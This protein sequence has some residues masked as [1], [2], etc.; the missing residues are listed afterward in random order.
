MMS[1]LTSTDEG[2][3]F[4]SW[5][6]ADTARGDV[7]GRLV[8]ALGAAGVPVW[9]DDGQIGA[10]DPIP[11]AVR[12]GL[13]RSK[14]LLAWYSEAYPT[15]RACREE[16]TLALLAAENAGLGDRRVLVIN[17][18][19]TLEHVVEA[20]L[21][22]RR[23][24]IAE[25]LAEPAALAA[26]IAGRV[27]ELDGPFGSL[28]VSG[29]PH[30]LFGGDGWKGGSH[31]FV[32]RLTELWRVHD[33]LHRT[34][35]LAGAGQAGRSVALVSGFGGVGKSLL[36]AEYA[37]LFASRYPGGVVWLS[38]AGHDPTGAALTAEQSTAAADTAIAELARSLNVDPSSPIDLS[39]LDKS[40]LRGWAKSELD[41][42]G[43]AVLWIVDDIPTRLDAAGLDAWRCPGPLV[44]ELITTRDRG[45]SRFQA[46]NLDVLHPADALSLLTQGRPLPSAEREQAEALAEELGYHP[47]A[48][49]VAGLYIA[50]STTFAG[51]RRLLAGNIGRFDELADQLADQL[52]GGHARQITA[53]LATSLERLGPQAWQLLW[54]AGVLAA[55]PIPRWF[56]VLVFAL[57]TT[58]DDNAAELALNQALQD[59]HCDGLWSYDPASTAVTVHVLVSA[60]ATALD[61]QPPER[62]LVR[63]VATATLA[64]MFE[65]Y[66]S[67][68]GQPARLNEVAVHARHLATHQ[69]AD[70]KLLTAVAFYEYRV[71]RAA[72]AAELWER[73]LSYREQI[74]G[75]EHPDTLI[76][77]SN[78]ASAYKDAGRLDE[79][80]ALFEQTLADSERLLGPDRTETLTSRGNLATAYHAAGRRDEA[81]PLFEQTGTD[82]ERLLG[83]D[84]PYTLTSRNNLASAYQEAGR[85]DRALPLFEQT[86]SDQEW[87]LGPDHPDTL[88]SRSNLASAYKDAGRRDEA[89]PLFEQ[90]LSDRLRILGRDHPDT[91]ASRNNLA[92]AYQDAGRL[93]EALPL[94]E[95]TLTDSERLLSPDHPHTL[96]SRSN[97]ASAYKDA[98][99][100]DEALPLFEQ[101]LSDRLR[102]LGRDHPDT[103]SSR[104]H[105]ALAYHE[106]GRLDEALALFEQTLTDRERFLGTDHPDTLASRLNLA[107]AYHRAGRLDEALPLFEQ[108]RTDSERLLGPDHPH[109]LTS[110]GDLAHAYQDAGRRDQ[111]LALFEQTVTDS[112]R[113]LGTDHPD[114]LASRLNLAVGYHKA[115][116]L[117]EALPLFEQTLTD[118]ERILGPDHP[119]TRTSRHVLGLVHQDARLATAAVSPPTRPRVGRRRWSGWLRRQLKRD[120]KR[121]EKAAN[122]GDIDAMYRF[123]V[124][125]L[126]K[127]DPPD[128]AGARRWFQKA[129][130]AGDRDAAQSLGYLL[131]NRLEPPDLVGARRWFQKAA[132]AGDRDAMVDLG[133][134][135]ADQLDPPDLYGARI[136]Y[137]KAADAGEIVAMYKLAIL[138]S[139]LDPPDLAAADRWIEKAT[140][141]RSRY[142]GG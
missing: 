71:G 17:P 41:R 49:D 36:A 44:H 65:R 108:T 136:W 32:G 37:H 30:W 4:L 124:L 47:L 125:L 11:D 107:N 85:L 102:I 20:R 70:P 40:M 8:D 127:K 22:D 79:A 69:D 72:A 39:S 68:I 80:L 53:T 114:T 98:G 50:G 77:R 15:R 26:R 48:C 132:E 2:G 138:L 142:E 13:G 56:L 86:L 46:V 33:L 95:Q 28:P 16:L 88:T 45:H 122:A 3:V 10:F 5:T 14:V 76:S 12:D 140:A 82:S 101:T 27:A 19:P 25:D 129:A 105:L 63:Q 121:D 134:L 66:R 61:P 87:I 78:L 92:D 111:A 141:A 104:H 21:L 137:E 81:L 73:V 117:D 6:R 135:L 131:A 96:T 24:A 94:F 74:L 67:D 31:R 112:E 58:G 133:D 52:P 29:Q 75:P 115:G 62:E 139:E 34:T 18:E 7:L 93:D 97:L 9:I 91:L 1:E 84:H 64:T 116:R 60:A 130:E 55:A 113:F 51:Y 23:F 120:E 100:L 83:P 54:L 38:A 109:T 35:G 123:A 43:R 128:L 106:A 57:L 42:R 126:H 59:R 90:T 118:R 99:R 89:L 103:L 110:R 119:D